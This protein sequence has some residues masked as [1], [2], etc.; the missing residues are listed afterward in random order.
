MKKYKLT[1]NG[2]PDQY[3]LEDCITKNELKHR[4]GMLRQYLNERSSNKPIESK[5]IGAFILPEEKFDNYFK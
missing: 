4:I 3:L 1:K 5:E 2:E